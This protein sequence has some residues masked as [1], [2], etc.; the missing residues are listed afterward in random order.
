MNLMSLVFAGADPFKEGSPNFFRFALDGAS[1]CG[2]LS[3][4]SVFSAKGFADCENTWTL[5]AMSIMRIFIFQGYVKSAP[6]GAGEG[7]LK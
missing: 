5:R 2:R 7:V 6:T 4:S 3:S 1:L